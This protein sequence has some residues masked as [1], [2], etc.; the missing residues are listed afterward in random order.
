MMKK[1]QKILTIVIPAYNVAHYLTK[2]LDSLVCCKHIESLDI[3][4]INDGSTDSTEEIS[5]NYAVTYS[6]SVRYIS[7]KNGGHGSVINTGLNMASGKYFSVMDGDDWGNSNALDHIVEIMT[8]ASEDVLAANYQTYNIENGETVHFR[9]GKIEY[10][11]SYS[12][13]ELVK[14][15]IPLVMHELFYKTALLRKMNLH[16]REK[17][18]YDDEEYC[19]F[20]FAK[21]EN[22][23]FIDEEYYIYRQGDVNQSMSITN[24]L[25]RF[26]DKYK[27]LNDMIRYVEKHDIKAP[28]LTYM[29][30]RI[31]NLITSL[32]FLWLIT[33]PDRKKGRYEVKRLRA[34]LKKEKNDYY[35]STTKL[36]IAFMVF[37]AL[38]FD[39]I[40]WVKFRDFRKKLLVSMGAGGTNEIKVNK[41]ELPMVAFVVATPLQLFNSLIIMKHHFP[42]QKADLFV[43]DIACDMRKWIKNR[44]KD[45]QIHKV[46]Y[47]YDVCK[48]PS[49]IGTII[50]H[51]YTPRSSRIILNDCKK[52]SYSDFFTTWVGS[53]ATW[54][55]TKLWK[56]NPNIRLHFYEEGTG[57]YT[58]PLY[59]DYGGIKYMYKLLGYRSETDHVE[60]VYVYC[61]SLYHGEL[62]TVEIGTVTENDK[63]KLGTDQQFRL[64]NYDKEILFFDNPMNKP[65][66]KGIE[67]FPILADMEKVV[68][69]D[70][71]MVRVHPRDRS[72]VYEE[73]GYSEDANIGI[74]WEEVLIYRDFSD[75]ILIT[76]FSTAVFTPKIICDQEPRVIFL[77]R[78][79]LSRR[80]IGDEGEMDAFDRFAEGVKEMY[81]DPSR[82]CIPRT[83]DEMLEQLK[84]WQK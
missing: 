42:D 24:Q 36:W 23:R 30:G 69:R 54:L 47:A 32:Y 22:I 51:I 19:M 60:D 26:H 83:R 15:G 52:T 4:I 57:V 18:S 11:R 1:N 14:S 28:N 45:S 34:W 84:E 80:S 67:Q 48:H 53:P 49:R 31:E 7:K 37:H 25:R 33:C 68:G 78:E 27:V 38:H 2:T 5:Q 65:E 63:V 9:F 13:R 61:P 59:Q 70:N 74:P 66:Y 76:T 44:K 46:Y 39:T 6:D 21:A 29:Q 79:L 16:I 35:K 3:I 17:V 40:R 72:G 55:Y 62:P 43:L 20:P 71:I 82:I 41:N 56:T 8:S 12:I 77:K 81:S 75:K 10:G 58:T 64:S 73:K 50:D